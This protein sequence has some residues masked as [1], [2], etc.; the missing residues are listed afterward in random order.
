MNYL[1]YL[2]ILTEKYLLN[3]PVCS[4]IKYIPSLHTYVKLQIKQ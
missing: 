3:T 4:L 2:F 1:K